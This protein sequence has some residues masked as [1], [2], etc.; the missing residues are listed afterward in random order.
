MVYTDGYDLS[1][2]TYVESVSLIAGLCFI[3]SPS[4]AYGMQT[5]PPVPFTP[6]A[7]DVCR[8]CVMLMGS[9]SAAQSA[10]EAAEGCGAEGCSSSTMRSPN[11]HTNRWRGIPSGRFLPSVRWATVRTS[12]VRPSRLTNHHRHTLVLAFVARSFGACDHILIW[13][14]HASLNGDRVEFALARGR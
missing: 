2:G 8:S 11:N 12:C 4:D 10:A 1:V 9:S 6:A 7:A 14:M 5:K 3:S 13:R